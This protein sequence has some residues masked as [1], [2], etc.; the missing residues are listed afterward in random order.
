[1]AALGVLVLAAP[2]LATG[3][4]DQQGTPVQGI[5][6]GP[7]DPQALV[8]PY[9]KL[10]AVGQ[11]MPASSPGDRQPH[12]QFH[13]GGTVTGWDGCNTIRATYVVSEDALKFGVLMG[14]LMTCPVPEKLDRH[15]REAL[16][17]TRGWK[18]ANG[19]LT[20]LDEA[21]DVLARFEARLDR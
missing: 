1:M 13:P 7:A 19:Q 12:L 11:A 21:G 16:V 3:L 17:I 14:T 15:L 6:Q 10:V 9:W 4:P 18:L 2:P 20:L 5:A 8:G